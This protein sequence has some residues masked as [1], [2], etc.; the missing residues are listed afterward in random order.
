MDEGNS[1]DSFVMEDIAYE[2]QQ[3][4]ACYVCA[5]HPRTTLYDH[6][7]EKGPATLKLAP[8]SLLGSWS[9]PCQRFQQPMA[10]H[11]AL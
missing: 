5:S 4:F 10:H 6:R 1:E 9:S 2:V 8:P 7:Q 11:A 3:N